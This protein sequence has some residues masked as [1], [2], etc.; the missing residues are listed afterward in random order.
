MEHPAQGKPCFQKVGPRA[1]RLYPFRGAL[2]L[3]FG[4]T[5]IALPGVVQPR[6]G[7][8]GGL[9]LPVASAHAALGVLLINDGAV[10]PPV[11]VGAM[12]A[13]YVKSRDV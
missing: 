5:V 10:A 9:V 12:R 4:D 3:G 1:N 2:P 6:D 11:P 13:T 8:P 7:L